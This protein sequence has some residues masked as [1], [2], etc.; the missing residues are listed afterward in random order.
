M[1]QFEV[2]IFHISLFGDGMK[3]NEMQ[4]K[5]KYNAWKEISH[6]SEQKAQVL[7]I[8]QVDTLINKYGTRS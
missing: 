7:Y 3:T 2:R 1:F 6:I 8:Q 4:A 5:Y